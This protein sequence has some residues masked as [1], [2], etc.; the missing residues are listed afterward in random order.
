[1]IGPGDTMVLPDV[2]AEIFEGEAE[3]AVVIGKRAENINEDDA[4]DHVFGY[5]NFIDG[6]ARGVGPE[7]NSFFQ[8]K[9]RATFAPLGP[10]LVT[11]DE[12]PDPQN[13]EIKMWVNGNVTHEFNTKAM[14]NSIRRCVSWLSSVHVLEPGDVIATGTDHRGMSAF[15][16]D[17]KIEL[18]TDGLGKLTVYVAD[19]L[20]R[21]W[22]R[23]TR[24]ELVGK[25]PSF[26]PQLTGK[27]G[28]S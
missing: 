4:M 26:E 11:K 27:Y 19:P 17:D 9:S 14:V 1:M 8:M 24:G 10:Y 28:K 16:D 25:T 2:P 3:M 13:L 5:V 15:Q 6:S 23:R 21:T 20:K 22:G 7:S 18:E 12:I